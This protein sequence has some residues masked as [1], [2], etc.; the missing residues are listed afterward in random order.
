MPDP[1]EQEQFEEALAP[2]AY[3]RAWRYACRL[4]ATREDAEDLLQE[5]LIRAYR[6]FSRL[7]HR[8]RFAAWLVSI[9]RNCYLSARRRETHRVV[10][11]YWHQLVRD[12]ALENPL[13]GP[14][15]EALAELPPAQREVLSL[16]YLDGL[17]LE[18][19]GWVL[20]AA[21]QV[22][23]QRLYRARRALRRLL[24]GSRVLGAEPQR[25]KQ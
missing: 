16:F 7:R 8:E 1:A 20:G 13:S 18:E 2:A 3:T 14:I 25:C 17:S 4:A 9:I 21:P 6:G 23:G 19:T 5:A 11:F 10:D 22:V 24:H 12:G 15:A